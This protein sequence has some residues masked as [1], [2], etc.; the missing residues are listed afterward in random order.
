MLAKEVKN[1]SLVVHN[2]DPCLIKSIQVQTPSARGAATLYKFRAQ[3]L[4]K[5][6][7]VD[8][9]LKGTE[10]LTEADFQKLPAKLMY[11][12]AT[13]AYFMEQETYEQFELLLEDLEYEMNF[14]TEETEGAQA[15]IYNE[16]CIGIQVPLTVEM[17]VVECDPGVKGNSATSRTKPAKL[18]T[19]FTVQVPE[20]LAQDEVIKVDTTTGKFVSRA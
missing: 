20:Y 19:G 4:R 12:D 16:E 14:I 8:I 10:S 17:K 2:G 13:K 18:E 1:G 6:E 7:K 5:K 9:T 3:N 11:T 15:L